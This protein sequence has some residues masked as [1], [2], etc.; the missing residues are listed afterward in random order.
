S[1]CVRLARRARADERLVSQS[2]RRAESS[3]EIAESGNCRMTNRRRFLNRIAQATV[4]A[5]LTGCAGLRFRKNAVI[6]THTHFYDPKRP[7][8]VPWPPREDK[9]LYRTVLPNHY[10]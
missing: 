4:A 8:E 5:S 7:Q 10:R 1:A 6:D 9:L 2:G 3:R